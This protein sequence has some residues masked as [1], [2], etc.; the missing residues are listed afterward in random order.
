MATVLTYRYLE[1]VLSLPIGNCLSKE[2]EFGPIS[3]TEL[4]LMRSNQGRRSNLRPPEIASDAARE[5]GH[6]GREWTLEARL[7]IQSESQDPLGRGM[8]WAPLVIR[9]H[10]APLPG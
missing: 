7:Q 10:N 4:M 8:G 2:H 3:F 5:R 6:N 1:S 9:S